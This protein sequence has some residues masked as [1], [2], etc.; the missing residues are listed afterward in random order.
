MSGIYHLPYPICSAGSLV[1]DTVAFLWEERSI[2]ISIIG[3]VVTD[4]EEHDR[5]Q[6]VGWKFSSNIVW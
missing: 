3:F 1:V 6:E 5:R 4:C 2:P